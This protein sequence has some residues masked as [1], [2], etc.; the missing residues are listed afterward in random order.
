M[1]T[2]AQEMLDF[3]SDEVGP[4]GWYARRRGGRPAHPRPLARALGARPR[5]RARRVAAARRAGCL[6]LLILLDQ[7]PRNMFRGD[8]RAFATDARALAVAKVAILR[9]A[10]SACR[11][12]SGSSSSCR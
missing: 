6:A 12:P 9:G 10:T 8:P 4:E 2:R 5:R 7:F 1:D 3:W 11:C